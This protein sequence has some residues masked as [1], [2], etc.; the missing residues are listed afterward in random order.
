MGMAL[1]CASAGI[2]SLHR[3]LA[4]DFVPNGLLDD[5]AYEKRLCSAEKHLQGKGP[6]KNRNSGTR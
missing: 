5:G 3:A 2:F 1:L 4:E 6:P